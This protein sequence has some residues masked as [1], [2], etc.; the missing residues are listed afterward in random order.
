[1][2]YSSEMGSQKKQR[3]LSL[4]E[5]KSDSSQDKESEMSIIMGKPQDITGYFSIHMCQIKMC[6]N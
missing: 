3:K 1:M 6:K 2:L 4:V 5:D